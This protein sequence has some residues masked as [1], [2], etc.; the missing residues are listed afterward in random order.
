MDYLLQA[1]AKCRRRDIH[2]YLIGDNVIG[3]TYIEK[4]D[5]RRLTFLGW[6]PHEEVGNYYAACDAV[7]MP[8]RWEAFGLVAVEAMKYGKPVIVSNRGA[9]PEIIKDGENGCV[10]DFDNPQTL[11]SILYK[12]NKPELQKLGAKARNDFFITL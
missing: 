5:T 3:G 9:L 7:I 10:F 4:K 11:K 1:F 6:V 8:S 2:L 12:L